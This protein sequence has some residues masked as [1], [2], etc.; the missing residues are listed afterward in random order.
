MTIIEYDIVISYC[1]VSNY[2]TSVP[3]LMLWDEYNME[4]FATDEFPAAH[5]RFSPV[6]KRLRI[7][8]HNHDKLTQEKLY[9]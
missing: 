6:N 7:F 4:S 9:Y 8:C 5:L 1:V 3:V 2:K